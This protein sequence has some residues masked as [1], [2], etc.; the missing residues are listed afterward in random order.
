MQFRKKVYV[1]SEFYLC[2]FGKK[3]M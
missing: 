3:P 1:I 2:N